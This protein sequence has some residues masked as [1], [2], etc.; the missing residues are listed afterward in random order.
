[1]SADAPY[2]PFSGRI[3]E[4]AKPILIERLWRLPLVR[5]GRILSCGLYLRPHGIEVRCGYDDERNLLMSQ[6][7]KTPD[8]ARARADEWKALSLEKGFSE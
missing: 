5:T 8:A 1:M 7:E 6:V 4:P 3:S 2:T